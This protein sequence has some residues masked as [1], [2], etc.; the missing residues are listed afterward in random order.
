MYSE[1]IFRHRYTLCAEVWVWVDGF[2][3]EQLVG[4]TQINLASALLLAT[5]S[6]EE[7]MALGQVPVW[8]AEAER[9]PPAR[10]AFFHRDDKDSARPSST[11][12]R[13]HSFHRLTQLHARAESSSTS[14]YTISSLKSLK[15]K[16]SDVDMTAMHTFAVSAYGL[17]IAAIDQTTGNAVAI[18]TIPK[19]SDDLVDAKR[20][21]REIC[22]MRHLAPHIVKSSTTAVHAAAGDRQV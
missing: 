16:P 7:D 4:V 1:Q 18:K 11:L 20:I 3:G 9:P 14:T 22:L 8:C 5:T 17:E 21:V 15:R 2:T 19:T 12:G 10:L 6:S 13:E